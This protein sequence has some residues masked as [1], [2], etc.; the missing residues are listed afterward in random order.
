MKHVPLCRHS[1]SGQEPQIDF[2]C[3]RNIPSRNCEIFNKGYQAGHAAGQ[4]LGE[5]LATE[6]IV[7]DLCGQIR[8]GCQCPPCYSADARTAFLLSRYER[9]D[10]IASGAHDAGAEGVPS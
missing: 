10:H 2:G 1:G 5:K 9:G 6:R 7:A 8:N 3:T 4:A